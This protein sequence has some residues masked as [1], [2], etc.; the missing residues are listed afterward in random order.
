MKSEPTSAACI[1][2]APDLDIEPEMVQLAAGSSLRILRRCLD[3]ADL[4]A[5]ASVEPGT[6][7]VLSAG[8]PR[9]TSEV[10]ATLQQ[11][12]RTI[13]GL[14]HDP[15]DHERLRVLGVTF[16]LVAR[17]PE[18]VLKQLV[19]A[20][21]S[22]AVSERKD[23]ETGAWSEPDQVVTPPDRLLTKLK[24]PVD[25]RM[26]ALWGPSGAP[27]RTTTALAVARLVAAAGKSV[28]V[29]DADTSGPAL[30]IMCGVV[31]D[32]SG[33][34]VAC[35]YAE[36]GT[37]HTESLL[38]VV[39]T[40]VTGIGI[41]GGV[42]HPDRWEELHPHSLR[43]VLQLCRKTFDY[44]CVDIGA[45][46]NANSAHQEIFGQQRFSAA[47]VALEESDAV[48]AVGIASPL[49]L[50]R[51]LQAL[52]SLSAV[53]GKEVAIAIRPQDA[54]LGKEALATL[55]AYGCHQELI[56]MPRISTHDV[57]SEKGLRRQRGLFKRRDDDLSA[58]EAWALR[59]HY[60]EGRTTMSVPT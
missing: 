1:V 26:L 52:S 18:V 32:A 25:G 15:A 50:S 14:A 12:G 20:L 39:R 55:R 48:L 42:S 40:V 4:L 47:A 30:T 54:D 28:C 16:A 13:I 7:V 56:A 11:S 2:A 43:H 58:L 24:S 57:V 37:L 21:L 38:S 31:E 60:G 5:V 51:L 9:L 27:G 45:G 41:I 59:C 33:V 35:R 44:T 23:W 10:V 53:A 29:I 6:P 19:T 36:N 22:P 46:V 17:T 8:L 3:A 49:G 34:V